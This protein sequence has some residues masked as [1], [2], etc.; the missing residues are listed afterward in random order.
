MQSFNTNVEF[1]VFHQ[2]SC[3]TLRSKGVSYSFPSRFG[4]GLSLRG[5]LELV[6]YEREQARLDKLDE[7]QVPIPH[8]CIVT[9]GSFPRTVRLFFSIAC[10]T[11]V[12]EWRLASTNVCVSKRLSPFCFSIW[13]LGDSFDWAN[14]RM[15]PVHVSSCFRLSPGLIAQALYGV[16][17]LAELQFRVNNVRRDIAERRALDKAQGKAETIAKRKAVSQEPRGSSP[18]HQ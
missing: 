4:G 13:L 9:H 8:S 15:P 6:L 3:G 2:C 1:H 17:D 16:S 14:P 18:H 12:M 11:Y 10:F 5:A 7:R